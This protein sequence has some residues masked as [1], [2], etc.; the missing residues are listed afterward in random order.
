[1]ENR[2]MAL[3]FL[4]YFCSGDVDSLATLLV[5]DLQFKG[6]LYQFSSRDGYLDS[7]K[8]DP[9]EKAGYQISSV[10]ES[11]DSVSIYYDYEKNDQVITIAQLFRFKKGRISELLLVFDGRGF[12]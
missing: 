11:G 7:L 6:P 8:D 1:M 4:N 9:L 5:V 2:D 12:V 10:T 3:Q